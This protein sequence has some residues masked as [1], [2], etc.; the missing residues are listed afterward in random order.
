M[1]RCNLCY[2]IDWGDNFEPVCTDCWQELIQVILKLS[3]ADCIPSQDIVLF[4]CS[5]ADADIIAKIQDK[6]VREDTNVK[7]VSS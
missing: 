1:A 7:Q 6:F 4:E 5:I 2:K 3:E